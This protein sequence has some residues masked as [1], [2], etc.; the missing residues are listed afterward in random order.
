MKVSLVIPA[1]NEVKRLPATL[2]Q[3]TRYMQNLGE[4]WELLVVDN[5]S[6]DGTADLVMEFCN[7]FSQIRLLHAQQPG[8]GAALRAGILAAQ[9]DVI[10]FSDADLSCPIEEEQKLRRA[11]DTGYDIA[12]AS[13][14]L[15]ESEVDKSLRRRIMSALF[16]W[17]VQALA[18]P[19]IKD[20]QCGFK[21][22]RRDVAH[23]LFGMSRVDGWAFDVEILFLARKAGYSIAE[24]PVRWGQ[25]GGSQVKIVRDSLHMVRDII[26]F[27]YA[28]LCG[29]YRQRLEIRK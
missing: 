13:R 23:T 18:L 25:V 20:S 17:V 19:G 9:G 12:I 26:Q 5:N 7:T 4:D 2:E 15:S 8:K 14:R 6:Q 24:V 11:L 22:F 28:W 1:K 21:A 3:V 29:A 27:R 10:L 16:N